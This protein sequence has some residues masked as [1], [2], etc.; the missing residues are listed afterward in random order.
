[1]LAPVYANIKQH[2]IARDENTEF[3]NIS[4]FASNNKG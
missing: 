4:S 3:G 2:A 1:M